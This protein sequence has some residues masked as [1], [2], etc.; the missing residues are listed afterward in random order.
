MVCARRIDYVKILPP[1][2]NTNI[3][4]KRKKCVKGAGDN[5]NRIRRNKYL[6]CKRIGHKRTM[7]EEQK[8]L[9]KL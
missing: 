8:I 4:R 5:F 3:G 7:C 2:V 1:L 6:I 9:N